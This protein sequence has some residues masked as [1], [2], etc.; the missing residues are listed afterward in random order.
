[1]DIGSGNSYPSSALSNFAPHPFVIDGIECNSMEGFL[2]SLKFAN[3]DVQREV[4]KLVGRA[5]KFK[6]QKRNKQW[7]KTQTLYWCGKA[8]K[9]D[10]IEYQQ[11]LDRAYEALSK[12]SGFRKAL[13]ASCGSNLTHSIGKHDRSETVLTEGEFITRLNKIRIKIKEGEKCKND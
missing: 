9:R 6:G 5:A 12:N 13:L 3:P 11:L 2:Q 7:R 10:S 1:M 4:C 8:Y